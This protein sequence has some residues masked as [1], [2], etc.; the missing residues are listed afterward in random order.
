[1]KERERKLHAVFICK[2]EFPQTLTRLGKPQGG[3]MSH[4][5]TTITANEDRIERIRNLLT[6]I[7]E[8]P[9]SAPPEK[10]VNITI[11]VVCSRKAELTLSERGALTLIF[12]DKKGTEYSYA[13]EKSDE[14]SELDRI[15][16]YSVDRYIYSTN[17]LTRYLSCLAIRVKH[18][19][20]NKKQQE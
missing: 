8:S 4:I 2:Y 16:S 10:K 19:K 15:L 6:Y 17:E 9:Q 1:M 3:T 14:L 13:V 18:K 12:E 11:F 7:E 20:E 5:H